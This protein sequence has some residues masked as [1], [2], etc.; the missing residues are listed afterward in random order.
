ML[1]GNGVVKGL[2]GV[3]GRGCL[4]EE[5]AVLLSRINEV[6][7]QQTDLIRSDRDLAGQ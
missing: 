4:R 3:G 7:I 5:L 1:I 6:R 2:F